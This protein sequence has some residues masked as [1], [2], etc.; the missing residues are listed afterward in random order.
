IPKS[1]QR[2]VTNLS[3]STN[4]PSSSSAEIRSRAVSLP[5][6]CC[7]AMRA[8]PPA[9]AALASISSRR[10]IGSWA[11][12]T[13]GAYSRG[14]ANVKGS[15]LTSR[16]LW[17]ELNQGAKGMERLRHQSSP[18]LRHSIE[19]GLNKAKWYPF[20]QFIELNLNID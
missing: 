7:L 10:A 5:A 17:V 12:M 6:S 18:D 11:F 1:A 8:S 20:E 9:T 16:I 13:A 14:V 3:S 19:M 4:E 15:A 2:C